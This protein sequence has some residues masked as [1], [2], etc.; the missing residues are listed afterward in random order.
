VKRFLAIV[1]RVALAALA[2]LIAFVVAYGLVMRGIP[3][4][5]TAAESSLSPGAAMLLA[6]ALNTAVMAWLILRSRIRGRRLALRMTA[7]FFGVQT[8]MAQVESWIFQFSP[9]FAAHLPAAMIPRIL[10]AGFLHA[11]LWVPVAVWILGRWT[12]ASSPESAVPEPFVTKPGLFGIAAAAYVI[13]Y[14]VFGYYVAWR[15][16]AV[17][18][19]YQGTDPGTLWLQLRSVLGDTPWL[20]L[21]QLLRGLAWTLLGL[22][23]VRSMRGAVVEKALALG[24]LFAVVMNTSLLLPN[25]YMPYAVRMVH[26][27]ETSSSN[28][29]FGVLVACLFCRKGEARSRRNIQSILPVC[30]C[31]LPWTRRV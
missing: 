14:F 2:Y 16:P 23:T 31:C 4:D 19:Y 20:P 27:V 26:L 15:S 30:P 3:P 21:A 12:A 13:L 25:P 28:F 5:P 6:A 17:R 22:A 9:G 29:L 18:D 7:V 11:C 10:L 1:A 24:S 8:F